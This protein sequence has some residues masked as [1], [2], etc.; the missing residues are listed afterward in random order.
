MEKAG[1]IAA[2]EDVEK[3]HK[4]DLVTTDRH[5]QVRA[6]MKKNRPDINLQFDIWHVV[7]G[8]VKKK[9]LIAARKKSCEEIGGWVQSICNHLW[10][11]CQTCGGDVEVLRRNWLG[12]IWHIQGIHHWD[13]V[14][15][16]GE[17]ESCHHE[18]YT[19]DEQNTT[20]WLDP[21][22]KA[23]DEVVKVITCKRLDKDL[24]HLVEFTH[25]GNLEVYHSLL[26]KYC[27]KDKHFSFIGMV[28]RSQLA[29][30]DINAGAGLEQA[31]TKDGQRRYKIVYTKLG[32]KWVRKPIKQHKNKQ[33]VHQME[34]RVI[35]VA[36]NDIDLPLPTIP[37]LPPNIAP[38]GSYPGKEKVINDFVSKFSI[39]V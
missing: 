25:T 2:L 27:P 3:T 38:P 35:E 19:E 20:L 32:K 8:A 12:A 13:T 23:Y 33:Y 39:E 11:C 5:V 15:R 37:D 14:M 1:F 7:K 36:A 31:T 17:V 4:V 22:S 6:Y 16:P 28:A 18:D 24:I 29:G 30:M 9:L 26:N 34:D 10:W 21:A